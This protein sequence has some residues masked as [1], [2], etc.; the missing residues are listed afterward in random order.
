MTALY[1]CSPSSSGFV[2]NYDPN[3]KDITQELKISLT[4]EADSDPTH[5]GE[6]IVH[7]TFAPMRG[8]VAD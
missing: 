5:A 3:L 1:T 6:H 7:L 2:P 4:Q 8:T